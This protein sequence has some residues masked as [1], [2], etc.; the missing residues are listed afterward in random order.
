MRLSYPYTTQ[1]NNFF[2]FGEHGNFESKDP[3]TTFDTSDGQPCYRFFNNFVLNEGHT[4][5]TSHPC[6]GLYIYVLRN[7]IINGSVS[8]T[9]RGI[10][11]PPEG[12]YANGYTPLGMNYV[13]LSNFNLVD[14]SISPTCLNPS[15]S[16]TSTISCG[17]GGQDLGS[18]NGMV[19]T[20]IG[21]KSGVFSGGAGAGGGGN[22]GWQGTSVRVGGGNAVDYGGAAA[23]PIATSLYGGSSANS[24]GGCGNP[25][26]SRYVYATG[27]SDPD[28][29]YTGTG[30]VLYFN[31]RYSI[32][33]TSNGKFESHGL[34]AAPKLS[35]GW[36]DGY[37]VNFFQ[38]GGSGGGIIIIQYGDQFSNEITINSSGGNF[39]GSG[40]SNKY[41][42]LP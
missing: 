41:H 11:S 37:N 15:K 30:G 40:F 25:G 4:L 10:Y 7:A 19:R 29:N 33:S 1:S 3:I 32:L 39:A 2:G 9:S 8:M 23:P 38:G 20:G 28:P 5:T 26:Y 14:L 27:K 6:R 35:L 31:C 18:S 21:G 22:A 36:G 13:R 34:T 12:E 16:A 42:V 17:G 24:G